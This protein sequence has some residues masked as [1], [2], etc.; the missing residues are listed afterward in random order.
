MTISTS[1]ATPTNCSVK[2]GIRCSHMIN[3]GHMSSGAWNRD[4]D[5]ESFGSYW[6]WFAI[7]V[8]WSSP[9]YLTV[10]TSVKFVG[11]I[12]VLL[13]GSILTAEKTSKTLLSKISTSFGMILLTHN[14]LLEL[15]ILHILPFRLLFPTDVFYKR[16]SN[17]PKLVHIRQNMNSQSLQLCD[18][19]IKSF[20]HP[21]K[22][23]SSKCLFLFSD[24]YFGKSSA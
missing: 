21:L 23:K 6:L 10:L 20:Q 4:V 17:N 9:T 2:A 1:W 5:I 19:W 24:P 13:N 7:L 22:T 8:H 15:M 3:H 11:W 16:R 12:T 14:T 18:E